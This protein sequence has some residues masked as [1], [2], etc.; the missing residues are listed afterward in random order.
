[1]RAFLLIPLLL[2]TACSQTPVHTETNNY[3]GVDARP[4][5]INNQI[6]KTIDAGAHLI[7]SH[8]LSLLKRPFT[9][10]NN[11]IFLGVHTS[12][13][14]VQDAIVNNILLPRLETTTIPELHKGEGM[15]LEEWEAHLDRKG[16]LAS[17]GE[18]DLLIDGHN[19][20]PR[21]E[22]S[23]NDAEKSIK[24]RTYIFDNDDVALS[25]ADLLK[26]RAEDIPVSVM[27]DGIGSISGGVVASA[28]TPESHSEPSTIYKYLTEN[29]MVEVR[30]QAN[31]W[32]MGDHTKSFIFDDQIA[33]IGGMNI[34]REYR[35]DWHDMMIELRGPIVSKIAEDKDKTW[36]NAGAFGDFAMVS[37]LW[38]RSKPGR[39]EIGPTGVPL[40]ILYTKPYKPQIYNVHLAAIK[41]AKKYIYI[42]NA[43]FSDDR[44]LYELIKARLRGVDVRVILPSRGDS[45]PMDKSNLITTNLLFEYGVKVYRYPGMSH[46]KAT[47][48]DGWASIGSANYDKLSLKLNEE[49]NIAT[50]DQTVVNQLLGKVFFPDFSKSILVVEPNEVA[51]NDYFYEKVADLIL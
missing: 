14:L 9:S 12:T 31:T 18:V 50:S 26:K 41:K 37:Q 7:N 3:P 8:S 19:F 40:R 28:S 46:I 5:R 34:G 36:L 48:V 42:Q 45:G 47:V 17:N 33:F 24:I 23:I 49:M 15:D 6:N 43:Y 20:F 4:K 2:I 13:G 21:F 1:M 51:L 27:Y 11:L 32:F 10:I 29:S 44:I 35:Y 30:R 25:I 38:K 16:V 22:K 39:A